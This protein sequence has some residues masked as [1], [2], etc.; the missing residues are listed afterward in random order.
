MA[1]DKELMHALARRVEAEARA[2]NRVR[3]AELARE[4]LA[5]FPNGHRANDV[6]RWLDP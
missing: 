4:Y 5:R 6:R 1:M 3:A 2:G